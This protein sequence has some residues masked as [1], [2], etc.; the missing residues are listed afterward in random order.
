MCLRL[1]INSSLSLIKAMPKQHPNTITK[2]YIK[3]CCNV[4]CVIIW[5]LGIPAFVVV[6]IPVTRPPCEQPAQHP[7]GLLTGE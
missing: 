5:I 2:N 7:I 4:G 6:G 1:R 3:M